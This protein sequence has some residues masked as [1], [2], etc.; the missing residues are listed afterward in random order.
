MDEKWRKEVLCYLSFKSIFISLRF[1][2]IANNFYSAD[3]MRMRIMSTS[4]WEGEN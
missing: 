3:I 4:E 2:R 1:V